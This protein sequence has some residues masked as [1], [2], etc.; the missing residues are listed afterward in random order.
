MVEHTQ[1][2]V[3]RALELIAERIAFVR[4]GLAD[5]HLI[6]IGELFIGFGIVG[7]D[8]F[9]GHAGQ[10]KQHRG[11][12]A[13]AVLARKAVEEHSAFRLGDGVEDFA[14]RSRPD[15]DDPKV[16]LQHVSRVAEL[17][18]VRVVDKRAVDVFRHRAVGERV[19]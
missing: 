3:R 1:D 12:Q 8:V 17:V 13:G 5:P 7:R 16:S 9:R 4:L 10:R 11:H 15:V 18:H 2:S 6:L 14:E 19:R